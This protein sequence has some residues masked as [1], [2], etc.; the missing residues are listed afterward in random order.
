MPL[1]VRDE[2]LNQ[3]AEKAQKILKAP[4]KDAIRQA[5][6]RVVEDQE[7]QLPVAKRLDRI[8]QR[9]RSMGA[10]LRR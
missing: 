4:T 2:R 5:L 1:Y 10:L 9:Y 8:R 7:K 6:E 3:L